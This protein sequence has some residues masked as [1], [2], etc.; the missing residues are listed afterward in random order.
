MTSSD[1][2]MQIRH[3]NRNALWLMLVFLTWPG[4]ATIADL[5]SIIELA[6]LTTKQY[7]RTHQELTR[8]GLI[9]YCDGSVQ[10]VLNQTARHRPGS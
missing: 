1:P 2:R 6:G 7:Q 10:L 9:A 5:P 8:L 3:V 4:T